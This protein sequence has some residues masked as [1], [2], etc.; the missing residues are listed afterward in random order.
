MSDEPKMECRLWQINLTVLQMY[1][2]TILMGMRKKGAHLNNFE[3]S[4]LIRYCKAID[5]KTC[6]Q[7]SKS[8]W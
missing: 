4:V 1:N 6:T 3:K 7:T 8:D 5:K 2:I